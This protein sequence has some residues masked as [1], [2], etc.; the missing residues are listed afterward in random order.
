MQI[1]RSL[2]R[3]LKKDSI[4]A[5]EKFL[6]KCSRKSEDY[7]TY[8]VQFSNFTEEQ[9]WYHY[10]SIVITHTEFKPEYRKKAI[11]YLCNINKR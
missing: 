11:E 10:Y 6:L 5:F 7:F 1:A 8:Y 2:N 4:I 9:K 3:V